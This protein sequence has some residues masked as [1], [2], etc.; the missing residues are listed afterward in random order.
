MAGWMYKQVCDKNASIPWSLFLLRL[1]VERTRNEQTLLNTAELLSSMFA[2]LQR[3]WQCSTQLTHRLGLHSQHVVGV[4]A[5]P[6][7][8]FVL[9]PQVWCRW[10]KSWAEYFRHGYEN[11]FSCPLTRKTKNKCLLNNEPVISTDFSQPTSRLLSSRFWNFTRSLQFFF[12]HFLSLKKK[13]I[14]RMYSWCSGCHMY[15]K[16]PSQPLEFFTSS[17]I[18]AVRGSLNLHF[19]CVPIP[20]TVYP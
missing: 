7:G 4:T 16:I 6:D 13:R 3:V 17:V 18:W 15:S 14:S 9:S 20:V 19:N 10:A 5:Q 2:V 11:F 8:G 12:C 1:D